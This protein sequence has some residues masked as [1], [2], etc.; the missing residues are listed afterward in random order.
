MSK[1]KLTSAQWD[2]IIS[3]LEGN[4]EKTESLLKAPDVNIN[5]SREQ[6]NDLKEHVSD[7]TEILTD[8]ADQL[9]E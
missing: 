1:V 7:I 6:I 8:I 9:A 3:S 2:I 4:L 5:L